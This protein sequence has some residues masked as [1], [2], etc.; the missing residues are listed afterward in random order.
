MGWPTD[1]SKPRSGLAR[2]AGLSIPALTFGT[3]GALMLLAAGLW[4]FN[5]SRFLAAAVRTPGTVVRN[6]I[7]KPATSELSRRNRRSTGPMYAPV[8]RFRTPNGQERELTGLGAGEAEYRE[9]QPVTVLIPAGHPERARIDSHQE[10][11]L[12]PI[13]V[14]VWGALFAG[15]GFLMARLKF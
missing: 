7:E 14:G 5:S 9:G 12:G 10:L 13:V 3:L 2:L 1:R 6:I 15:I 8:V 11:W 4:A